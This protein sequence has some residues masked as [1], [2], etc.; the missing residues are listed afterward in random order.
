V[1]FGGS[2]LVVSMLAAGILVNIARTGEQARA[3][4]GLPASNIVALS[5]RRALAGRR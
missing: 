2:A 4:S 3:S 5:A 1:S